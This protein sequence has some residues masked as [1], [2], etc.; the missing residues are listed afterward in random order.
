METG[1]IFVLYGSL[2]IV[3]FKDI[4]SEEIREMIDKVNGLQLNEVAIGEVKAY[5]K[6]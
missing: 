5:H 2:Q 1:I 4:M 3:N 6:T